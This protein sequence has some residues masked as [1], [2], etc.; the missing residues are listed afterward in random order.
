MNRQ[1]PFYD[2]DEEEHSHDEDYGDDD[3]FNNWQDPDYDNGPTGHG[4]DCYS[5]AD[6][7]L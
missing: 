3:D 5:D 2:Y 6:N 1:K 7:G 4:D